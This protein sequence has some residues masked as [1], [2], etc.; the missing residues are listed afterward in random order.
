[1][2]KVTSRWET[3]RVG[4]DTLEQALVGAADQINN[5]LAMVLL[6]VQYVDDLVDAYT[7]HGNGAD[8]TKVIGDI[9][10]GVL[11]IR[12]VVRDLGTLAG[13]SSGPGEVDIGGVA[14]SMARL[15]GGEPAR[16]ALLERNHPDS[17]CRAPRHVVMAA[18][19]LCMGELTSGRIDETATIDVHVDG[20]HHHVLVRLRSPSARDQAR[21]ATARQLLSEVGGEVDVIETERGVQVELRL[22]RHGTGDGH[23]DGTSRASSGVDDLAD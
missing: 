14:T 3:A 7:D 15:I 6:N 13:M 16:T 22:P 20:D 19:A 5:A 1:M 8:A 17:R 10:T 2:T 21:F 4:F 9:V 23:G 11:R 12:D 18:L